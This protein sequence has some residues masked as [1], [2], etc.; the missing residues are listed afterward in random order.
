MW[1][2]VNEAL[3]KNLKSKFISDSQNLTYEKILRFVKLRGE[4]LQKS[5]PRY[6]KCAILC[7]DEM[8]TALAIISCWFAGLIP[9][10][11]SKNYGEKHYKKIL[12]Q[13]KPNL[14][15]TDSDSISFGKRDVQNFN[16]RGG[17]YSQQK[18]DIEV[19]KSLK[20]ISVIL[21]TS[22][23]TGIPKGVL[24]THQGLLTN[25][26]GIKSYLKLSHLD[27]IM[28][29]RSLY[30]CSVFTGEFLVAISQGANIYF[31]NDSFN[32]M[33]LITK[34]K[35]N[36]ITICGGTP[37]LFKQVVTLL[38]RTKEVLPIKQLSISGE[39]LTQETAS[40]VRKAF[41]ESMIFNSYGQTEASPRISYLPSQYFDEYSDSVGFALSSTKIKICSKESG[42]ILPADARGIIYVKSPSVMKGYYKEKILTQKT[43]QKGWLK[44]N[45]FGYI[46]NKG[47]LYVLSR[48]DD[49]IIKA[50]MNVYPREIENIINSFREVNE[51]IV[52]QNNRGGIG[53]DVILESKYSS[54][55]KQEF[56]NRSLESLPQFQ[57]PNEVNFVKKIEKSISEKLI[58][59]KKKDN[60]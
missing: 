60:V 34:I 52:Y 56:L 22:G 35:E 51:C 59:R 40:I 4:Q 41:K 12:L 49:L 11:L 10:P 15:I 24:L 26:I 3:K 53:V 55:S 46:D 1:K 28:I 33:K 36:N 17:N 16:I 20:G 25:I 7:E 23:T 30:H 39:C 38:E 9:I 43:I 21:Y 57:M 58:R 27:N 29:A 19:D 18:F 44:T 54:F 37:T 47:F 48:V 32:P 31:F 8:Y 14:I 50:G 2:Y 13:S 6:S 45:D 5:F 42:E